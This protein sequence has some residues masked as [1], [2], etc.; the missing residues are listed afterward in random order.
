MLLISVLILQEQ[1]IVSFFSVKKFTAVLK[2]LTEDGYIKKF[3]D[4]TGKSNKCWHIEVV[5]N[6]KKITRFD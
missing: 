1:L 2:A 3:I 5:P 4:E 6:A